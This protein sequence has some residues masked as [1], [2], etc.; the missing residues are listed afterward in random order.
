M[1]ATSGPSAG[2]RR[3]WRAGALSV[4][5]G[6]A[7]LVA[8]SP[9]S[10]ASPTATTL[11]TDASL[12]SDSYALL[13][14]TL[15][16]NGFNVV[17]RF[18]WGRTTKYGKTTPVTQAGNGKAD[19]PVDVSLDTLKPNTRY[20]YRL[21]VSPVRANGDFAY[22]GDI[23]GADQTFKTAPRLGLKLGASKVRVNARG[24][25]KIKV[26]GIGPAGETAA[27]RLTL[28]AKLAGKERAIGGTTF[29][30]RHGKSKTLTIKLSRAARTALAAAKGHKLRVTAVVKTKGVK[31]AVT[32][33]LTLKA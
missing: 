21:V 1:R 23:L 12:L 6:V 5:C 27:G 24:R 26:K 32:H 14:G 20:H 7:A 33:K 17:Y 22:L 16:P 9:A 10:A 29:K 18:Q 2:T 15:N 19:V 31:A 3:A 4:V 8:T 30:V 28:K 11:P 25:V 13:S